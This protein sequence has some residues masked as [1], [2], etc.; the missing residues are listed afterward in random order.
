MMA[1]FGY[2]NVPV[3]VVISKSRKN[4]LTDNSISM[5]M[6]ELSEWLKSQIDE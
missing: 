4:E 3:V 6:E 5:D 2:S 1:E